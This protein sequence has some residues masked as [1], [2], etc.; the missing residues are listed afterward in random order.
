MLTCTAGVQSW[1]RL[2]LPAP[3]GAA[4]KPLNISGAEI[5]DTMNSGEFQDD[6]MHAKAPVVHEE[7]LGNCLE[8]ANAGKNKCGKEA[9]ATCTG[10]HGLGECC[11]FQGWCGSGPDFCGAGY[12]VDYSHGKNVCKE[13]KLTT[14]EL[15][16]NYNGPCLT[17]ANSGKNMCGAKAG[18]ACSGSHGLGPCCSASG[19]CGD[20]PD[21]CGA[22]MQQDYSHGAHLCPE[23]RDLV[24][25]ERVASQQATCLTLEEVAQVWMDA[26]MPIDRGDAAAMCVPALA[27]AGGCSFKAPGCND[28][29]PKFHPTVECG[30]GK[31]I[32]QINYA[33]EP[34][35]KAQA[36]A[37]Y[38]IYT[39]NNPDYGCLSDWCAKTDCNEPLDGIG[40]DDKVI[41]RH[42]FC[43]GIW[44]QASQQYVARI[45][46]MGG[47]DALTAACSKA[48]QKHGGVVVGNGK[49]GS[50]NAGEEEINNYL[51]EQ[52]STIFQESIAI[53]M[54]SKVVEA[55]AQ[56]G[57]SSL[58]QA[59]TALGKS[60]DKVREVLEV[61][62]LENDLEPELL[63]EWI[64]AAP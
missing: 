30:T 7:D 8:D 61:A 53:G 44:Q 17:D 12:Q 11:S 6:G 58:A 20:G 33:Y 10:S 24:Q 38:N 21:F 23:F 27:M 64:A 13:K 54:S 9:G 14:A 5:V 55:M 26:V 48:G 37:V 50:G 3:E 41:Q 56:K 29:T 4:L 40:Q 42:R 1:Q 31:G 2:G 47:V 18:A 35:A 15:N 32:W 16:K 39:S 25:R 46:E 57:I 45:E 34:D 28:G 49:K 52:L 43:K 36:Q 62:R 59:K 22:G 60:A 63:K 51:K 19:W